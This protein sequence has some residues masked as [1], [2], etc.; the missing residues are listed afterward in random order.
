MTMDITLSIEDSLFTPYYIYYTSVYIRVGIDIRPPSTGGESSD[1]SM[2][3][4]STVARPDGMNSS[5]I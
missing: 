1:E 4:F 3:R 5:Y 2:N